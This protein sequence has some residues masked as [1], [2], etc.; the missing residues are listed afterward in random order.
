MSSWEWYEG[1]NVS[2]VVMSSKDGSSLSVENLVS[3]S[4]N[5]SSYTKPAIKF[6]YT[7]AAVN[8]FPTNEKFTILLIVVIIGFFRKIN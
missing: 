4:Y 5:L 2:C 1:N 6:K 8:T 7:G 3:E